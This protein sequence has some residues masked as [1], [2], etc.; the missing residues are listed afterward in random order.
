M[1]AFQNI[2]SINFKRIE[3]IISTVIEDN[4]GAI[5]VLEI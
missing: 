4:V 1:V 2:L 5:L 3:M